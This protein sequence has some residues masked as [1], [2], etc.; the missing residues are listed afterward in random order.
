MTERGN[1]QLPLAT[2]ISAT[3]PQPGKIVV[4]LMLFTEVIHVLLPQIPLVPLQNQF[5]D[6]LPQIIF[7]S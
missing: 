7:E 3:H 4:K 6:K 5:L 1:I 2:D